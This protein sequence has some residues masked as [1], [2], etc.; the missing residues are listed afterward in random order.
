[1][2]AP[3]TDEQITRMAKMRVA[4][5]TH[6]IVYVAVNVFLITVWYVTSGGGPPTVM[7][8][9]EQYFWPMWPILG[10][11]LGLA[12]HGFTTYGPGSN[13]LAREEEKIRSEMGS[14]KT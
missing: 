6:L 13:M 7:D 5:K 9:R 4:F 8:N 12:I 3:L 1:M 10:W 11:G 2:A 14:G